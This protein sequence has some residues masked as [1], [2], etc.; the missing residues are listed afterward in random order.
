MCVHLI[1]NMKFSLNFLARDLDLKK[2]P[3]T[4]LQPPFNLW[5][6]KICLIFGPL[7]GSYVIGSVVSRT[8]TCR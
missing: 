2:N 6:L 4:G 1:S 8:V 5:D 7:R 3:N